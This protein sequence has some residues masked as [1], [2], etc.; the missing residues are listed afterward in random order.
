LKSSVYTE[1]MMGL[2]IRNPETVA[3]ARKL[4]S[5]KGQGLTETIHQALEKEIAALDAAKA[6]TRHPIYAATEAFH[7][8]IGLKG[9]T[10][11]LPK[12][13]YDDLYE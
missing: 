7:K 2:S 5:R 13:F 4:A 8:A 9:T 10:E 1:A 6:D 12:S 11:P 3:L